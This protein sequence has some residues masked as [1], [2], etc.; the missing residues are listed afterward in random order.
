MDEF[1]GDQSYP[2][3]LYYSPHMNDNEVFVEY[4]ND[5]GCYTPKSSP[6]DVVDYGLEDTKK[7]NNLCYAPKLQLDPSYPIDSSKLIY[8]EKNFDKLKTLTEFYQLRD[9]E[10]KTLIR[11]LETEKMKL[12]K[13]FVEFE[14]KLIPFEKELK[15]KRKILRAKSKKRKRKRHKTPIGNRDIVFTSIFSKG[16]VARGVKKINITELFALPKKKI[17]EIDVKLFDT[18]YKPRKGRTKDIKL[19]SLGLHFTGLSVTTKKN[20]TRKRKRRKLY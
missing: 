12:N 15:E 4:L 3:P 16:A 9:E 8:N 2:S 5:Y 18:Q 20:K 11:N 1:Y 7:N 13:T 10:Q 17:K 19:Q 14:A 6:T